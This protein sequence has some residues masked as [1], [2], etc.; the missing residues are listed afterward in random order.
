MGN[1]IV[2]VEGSED[3][4]GWA[5]FI[6]TTRI[7]DIF[8]NGVHLYIFVATVQVNTTILLGLFCANTRSRTCQAVPTGR[9]HSLRLLK[10]GGLPLRPRMRPL[11][12]PASL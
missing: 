7:S 11:I 2:S 3:D 5:T 10:I 6:L 1:G 9:F 8:C 4:S 12:R